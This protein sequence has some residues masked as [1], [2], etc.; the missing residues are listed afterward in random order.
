[1][2]KWGESVSKALLEDLY[3]EQG[4]SAQEIADK[5]GVSH[6]KVVYWMDKFDIQRRSWSEASYI[7]HNPDGEKFSIDTSNRDLFIAGIALYM[8]EGGKTRSSEI[9][10][11]NSNAGV[12]KLWVQFLNEVCGVPNENLKAHISYYEDLDYSEILD[13]WSR[14]LNISPDNF[15][16]PTM[17]EGR[18]A[19]GN[20]QE[21]RI[22]YG[23]VHVRFCDSKLKSL[24]MSWID[25]LV[26]GKL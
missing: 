12:L 9:I 24:L 14:T 16:S 26:K 17:K 23:T 2:L 13:F 22:P 21:R 10:L 7:K 6:H 1:M 4:L 20:Y 15:G 8:G 5:L 3:L 25:D 11:V 18:V 19:K